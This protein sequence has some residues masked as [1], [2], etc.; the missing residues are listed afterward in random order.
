M[1]KA[2]V[3]TGSNSGDRQMYMDEARRMLAETAGRITD[4]S[5]EFVSEPWG[6]FRGEA[7]PF[8]N[9]VL[10]IE[11]GLTPVKLLDAV[12][13]IENRLG[14]KRGGAPKADTRDGSRQYESRT[15][16]IDILFY[17]DEVIDTERLVI[18]HPLMGEREFV[19]EPLAAVM[20][21][22][23]HPV[24]GESVAGMLDKL[25]RNI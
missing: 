8:L 18:P 20:P 4:C 17:D 25:R 16:D 19:L 7:E 1:A 2:V 5:P 10:V 13:D 23:R 21:D 12:Q 6:D 9:Q 22:R 24:T 14:R 15:I 3:I 11:T